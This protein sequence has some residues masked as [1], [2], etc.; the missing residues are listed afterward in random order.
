LIRNVSFRG[1]YHSGKEPEYP[2]GQG[3][4][5]GF[6]LKCS[7]FGHESCGLRRIPAYLEMRLKRQLRRSQQHH[8]QQAASTARW[9][10]RVHGKEDQ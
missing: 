9:E 2:E 3:I 7:D 10:T 1:T 4:V 6:R 5:A 8:G